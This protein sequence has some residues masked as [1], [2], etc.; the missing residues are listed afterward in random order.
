MDSNRPVT[1]QWTISMAN[2]VSVKLKVDIGGSI[3]SKFGALG[4]IRM[5]YAIYLYKVEPHRSLSWF[6]TRTNSVYG[7]Y[8]KLLNDL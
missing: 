4:Q 8:I 1:D 5:I 6:I 7:R 3:S 2:L